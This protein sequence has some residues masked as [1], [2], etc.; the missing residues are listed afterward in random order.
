MASHGN[1]DVNNGNDD[2]NN[3]N[4]TVGTSVPNPAM[5]D[6]NPMETLTGFPPVDGT[7]G[8]GTPHVGVNPTLP[9]A[10]A[11]VIQFGT[12]PL[13]EPRVVASVPLPS[14]PAPFLV[15]HAIRPDKFADTDF[16]TWQNKMIFYLTTLG[17]ARFLTEDAPVVAENDTDMHKR[18]VWDAWK[19]ADFLCRN[20]VLD[21]LQNS[22]YH[23]YVVKKSAKE[24][25]ESLEKKYKSEDA[26]SKKFLASRCMDFEMVDSRGYCYSQATVSVEGF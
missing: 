6:V 10:T 5:T 19:S 3:G 15:N 26:G 7:I 11:S 24:L 23:V 2:V 20:Y 9:K 17:L 4:N 16:K 25:W 14:F 13:P 22:L 8:G 18:V 21:G 1:D 12:I